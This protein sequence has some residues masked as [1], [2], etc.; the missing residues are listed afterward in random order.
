MLVLDHH[1]VSEA[2]APSEAPQQA[3]VVDTTAVMVTVDAVGA[4]VG[5]MEG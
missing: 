4:V 3:A 1:L 5:R 2:A